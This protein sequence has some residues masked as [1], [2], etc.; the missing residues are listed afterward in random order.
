MVHFLICAWNPSS[1]QAGSL[2]DCC[3]GLTNVLAVNDPCHSPLSRNADADDL[4]HTR[5]SNRQKLMKLLDDFSRIV[6]MKERRVKPD[7]C[8]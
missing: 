1:Q 2:K 6:N 5:R 4:P 8:P 3:Q 7:Q